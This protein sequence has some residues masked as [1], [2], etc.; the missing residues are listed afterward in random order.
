MSINSIPTLQNIRKAHDVIRSY[1]HRTPVL[2]NRTINDLTGCSF[3]FKCENFQKVGAFKFRGA[4][5]AVMTLSEAEATRGVATHSSGNHAQALALAAHLR[6]IQAHIVMPENAPKVKV[7]AVRAY[8]ANIT[9]CEATLQ[10]RELTLK[11][12]VEKTGSTM[13]H[14]YNDS[15]IIAGQGTVALELLS[16]YPGLDMILAP[17]GGGGLLSGIALATKGI[18][19]SIKVFGCEPE[20]ADDAY[21]SF[22]SGKIEP[23][24]ST[25]TIADGLRTQLGTL[26]FEAIKDHVDEIVTVKETTIIDAM[27][28]IWERMKIIVEPSAAVPLAAILEKKVNAEGKKVGVIL[29]GGNMDLDNLPW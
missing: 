26:T 11:L 22:K 19:P 23:V 18:S 21:R 20:L 6:G 8:G 17:V 29:T 27:R 2:T 12:V 28:L 15:R 4:C 9:F 24:M 5:N 14:P 25:A 16:E 10:A 1:T 3:F 7:A 13:I